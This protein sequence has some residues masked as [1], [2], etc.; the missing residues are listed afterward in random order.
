MEIKETKPVWLKVMGI[1]FSIVV[2]LGVIFSIFMV[3][4]G[5]G[6]FLL[7]FIFVLPIAGLS[8]ATWLLGILINFL[9]KT[10][11]IFIANTIAVI[12]VVASLIALISIIFAINIPPVGKIIFSVLY[13]SSLF[14]LIFLLFIINKK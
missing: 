9:K 10:G 6:M 13:A 11:K 7:F 8:L 4:I 3:V 5:E 14:Y 12:G 2:V 1:I